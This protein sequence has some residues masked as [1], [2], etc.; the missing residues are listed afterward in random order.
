MIRSNTTRVEG[1]LAIMKKALHEC[2]LEGIVPD[3]KMKKLLN[4]CVHGSMT[5][6][7]VIEALML[8]STKVA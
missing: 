4:K 8:E 5:I 3:Q 7:G 2:S 1:R 6:D